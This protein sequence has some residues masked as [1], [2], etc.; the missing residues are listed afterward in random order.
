[1]SSYFTVYIRRKEDKGQLV[2]EAERKKVP[3]LEDEEHDFNIR[4]IELLS[5]CTTPCRELGSNVVSLEYTYDKMIDGY[6]YARPLTNEI[7]DDILNYYKGQVSTYQDILKKESEQVER[8]ENR[9]DRCKSV[10]VYERI[11]EELNGYKEAV[12]STKEE[13]EMYEYRL[14]DFNRLRN[15]LELNTPFGKGCPY[16]LIYTRD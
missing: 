4:G 6:G 2:P 8:L 7:L 10:A 13:L 11:Q 16:E 1:M 14:Y 12:E 5:L 15:I 9:L 3:Y